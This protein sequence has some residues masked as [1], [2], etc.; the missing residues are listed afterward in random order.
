MNRLRK[1]ILI[2]ATIIVAAYSVL[3]FFSCNVGVDLSLC[4]GVNC[5]N[6]GYCKDGQCICQPGYGG[7]HCELTLRD[8]FLGTWKGA[9]V[10]NSTS[11]EVI[12]TINTSSSVFNAQ[13]ANA[14]GFG[15]TITGNVGTNSLNFVDESIGG[16]NTLSGRMTLSK[17]ANS[18]LTNMK[19]EYTVTS[20]IGS[21]YTCTGE[22][23]KQ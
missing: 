9:D 8:P 11:S 6:G 15:T 19:F 21:S 7:Y 10:C 14:G 1:L 17:D 12:I 23:T 4:S 5:E 16:G 2:S 13:V 3:T 20:S 22:Y 18:N